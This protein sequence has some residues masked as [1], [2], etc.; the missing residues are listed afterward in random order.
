MKTPALLLVACL[1]WLVVA[2]QPD[3]AAAPARPPLA[4]GTP[5]TPAAAIGPA[6]APDPA[7]PAVAPSPA[8]AQAPAAAS[9]E[10]VAT[11]RERAAG[12]EN[13]GRF[14]DAAD[15]Y[16]QLVTRDPERAEWYLEAG[17]CLGRSGRFQPAL[18]LLERARTRFPALPEVLAMLARTL[19][20]EAESGQAL[21]PEIQWTDAAAL[22][23]EVLQRDANHLDCRLLLAQAKFLLGDADAASRQAEEAER[24]HP[25]HPGAAVLLGRIA[26]E[27]FRSLL[28]AYARL[29][30]PQLT[31]ERRA[32]LVAEIDQQRQLAKAA[33]TRAIARDPSRAHPHLALAD[34]AM[35][36]RKDELARQHFGDALVADPDQPVDH[37]RLTA[38]QTAQARATFYRGLL[39]R[40]EARADAQPAK[41][42]TLRWHLARALFDA[43]DWRG[44]AA[45]FTAAVAAAPT[46]TNSYYYLCLCSYHLQDYD[47]AEAHAAHYAG[48]GAAEFADVLRTLDVE[49]RSQMRAILQFLGDRAFQQGRRAAS[50]DINHT[51]A[52]LADS[53]D[54]WNNH[55]FLCR[56]TGRFE[57]AFASY[58]HAI[59]KEPTSAQLWNDAAVVLQY[60]LRS[61]ENLARAK[62][63]Y[64]RAITLAEQVLADGKATS[65]QRQA[66]E[67]AAGDARNNLAE[68]GG[69]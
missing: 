22:C 59:E 62:T 2:C 10:P 67:K 55:A 68:L 23:D 19:L 39:E 57:A 45:A 5:A 29:D 24:R 14:G 11:L 27:R 7:A 51:I 43:S 37:H 13:R 61:A 44:A 46:A 34:L 49:A 41:A 53:A 52:C 33:F 18:E 42:A 12:H 21:H 56:E 63:M 30:G 28:A 35:L 3:P 69:G 4:A 8:V 47:A 40:Y 60:H 64:E 26:S 6:A 1:P 50:R 38:G 48:L 17:R 32:E 54:A 25:S 9:Q 58:Q 65:S 20:L 66:A 31:D 15:V 36:D 16:L